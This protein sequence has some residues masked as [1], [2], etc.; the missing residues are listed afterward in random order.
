MKL[1]TWKGG[2]GISKNKWILWH[3]SVKIRNW[4]Q[5]LNMVN[6]LPSKLFIWD[7]RH[8]YNYPY[9]SYNKFNSLWNT[10]WIWLIQLCKSPK[11]QLTFPSHKTST[12]LSKKFFYNSCIWLDIYFYSNSYTLINFSWYQGTRLKVLPR[13]IV[14]YDQ[15]IGINAPVFYSFN[16]G[17]FNY[18]YL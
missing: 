15:D 4:K 14:A 10:P 13:D 9:N 16:S 12:I 1:W 18:K 2:S 6:L 3:P 7:W 5:I 11:D 8:D 17:N